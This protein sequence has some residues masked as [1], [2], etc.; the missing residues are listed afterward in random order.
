V[1]RIEKHIKDYDAK[2][3]A[4]SATKQWKPLK[5]GKNTLEMSPQNEQMNA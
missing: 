2:V 4:T 5:D 3:L 1:D